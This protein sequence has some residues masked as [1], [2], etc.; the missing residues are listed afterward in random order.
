M[1]N[2]TYGYV[3]VSEKDQNDERQLQAMIAVGVDERF[4]F[5][6]KQSG[7][8]FNRPQYSILKNALREGDLLVVKSIDRLGRNYKE[9]LKEWQDI[10]KDIR[11]DIKVIDMD[12]LDTRIHKDLLGAFISDLVLQVLAYVAEQERHYIK[13]RQR[14]GIDLAKASG[15]HLGRPIVEKPQNFEVV[16]SQWR[17]GEI[18]A[19]KAMELVGLKSTTF[20][21]MLKE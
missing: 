15:K 20:Y 13:Q 6:D 8:D 9:I 12:L 18:T 17:R 16:C 7:K 3:R 10:T 19:R 1:D 11:A 21:K 14:E 4:V 2:R 5:S